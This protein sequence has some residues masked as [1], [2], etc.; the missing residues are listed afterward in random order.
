MHHINFIYIISI[1][2]L[3][4]CNINEINILCRNMESN[5]IV[6][7]DHLISLS[8]DEIIDVSTKAYN[9]LT[10]TSENFMRSHNVRLTNLLEE[11]FY[12][13]LA[14][15]PTIVRWSSKMV[16]YY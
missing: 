14:R 9:V 7:I 2:Y 6:L 8:E 15:L 13:V 4:I 11:K 5:I 16:S 1:F 12:G 10:V 3:Y